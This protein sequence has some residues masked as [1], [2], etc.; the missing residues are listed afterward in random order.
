MHQCLCIL[1]DV[2]MLCACVRGY[3]TIVGV[4]ACTWVMCVRVSDNSRCVCM[5]LGDV[6]EGIRQ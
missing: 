3:Q 5:H 2:C 1:I 4:Y 6:C